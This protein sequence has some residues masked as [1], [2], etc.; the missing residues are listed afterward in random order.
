MYVDLF[1]FVVGS[2]ALSLYYRQ[3]KGGCR[4]SSLP[5]SPAPIFDN[6]DTENHRTSAVTFAVIQPTLHSLYYRV[7]FGSDGARSKS[8]ITIACRK[9]QFEELYFPKDGLPVHLHFV[10]VIG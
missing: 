8:L 1:R 10:P 7:L 3:H 6:G 2:H 5:Q 9:S 4:S